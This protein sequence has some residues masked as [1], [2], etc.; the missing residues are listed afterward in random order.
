MLLTKLNQTTFTVTLKKR[1][2][3][4]IGEGCDRYLLEQTTDSFDIVS[5]RSKRTRT[6]D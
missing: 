4:L 3:A 1:P 2:F 6:S 5:G